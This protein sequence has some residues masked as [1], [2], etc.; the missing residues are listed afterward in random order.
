MLI[1]ATA[2]IYSLPL[3]TRNIRDFKGCGIEVF[4]PFG[5]R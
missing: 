2:Q 4:D 3:A 1:A 5:Q